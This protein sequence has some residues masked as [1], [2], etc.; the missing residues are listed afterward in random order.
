MNFLNLADLRIVYLI[1]IDQFMNF[2]L[3]RVY[4]FM[5]VNHCFLNFKN[6][7]LELYD[8]ILNF[9]FQNYYFIITEYFKN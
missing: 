7:F 1:F 4:C 8:T 5:T 3:L 6:M 2:E 9:V